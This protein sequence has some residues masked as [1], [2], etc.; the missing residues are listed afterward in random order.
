KTMKPSPFLFL[1]NTNT[2]EIYKTFSH[3]KHRFTDGNAVS[4]MLYGIKHVIEK[5]GSLYRCF[6]SGF[7]NNDD[8][9]LPALNAFVNELTSFYDVRQN[10]L[11]PSPEKGSAI[12]RLNLF[13]R[14]M[15]R[16]DEVDPGGWEGIPASKLVIPLDTHMHK[17]GLLLKLTERK[18]ANLQTAL[19]ITYAFRKIIPEDPV[20]YDFALTRMGIRK[21]LDFHEFIR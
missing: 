16:Y 3:F 8:I 10:S 4:E 6:M 14:W 1:K 21:E 5:Y 15:V 13:L 17:I 18:Q 20:R 2:R 12:K 11:L 19:E 7:N 9:I